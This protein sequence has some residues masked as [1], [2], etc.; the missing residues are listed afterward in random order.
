[1][2]GAQRAVSLAQPFGLA[3]IID[4]GLRTVPCSARR[5]PEDW[6]QVM[7]H[8]LRAALD[9][10]VDQ[11]A[12]RVYANLAQMLC[13][14]MRLTEA[15]TYVREGMAYCADHDIAAFGSRLRAILGELLGSVRPR[16]ALRA[17]H[18]GCQK[19]RSSSTSVTPSP[20]S[21]RSWMVRSARLSWRKGARRDVRQQ[22]FA[23]ASPSSSTTL[24]PRTVARSCRPAMR[25]PDR[26][27]AIAET[28]HSFNLGR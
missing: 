2:V 3:Q 6:V 18:H 28:A 14:A 15:E 22:G 26:S 12:A 17:L 8:S 16:V 24:P 20:A 4:D 25:R 11:Q 5:N 7:R 9:R 21:S 10:G 13:R 1:M 23:A 27:N 19:M